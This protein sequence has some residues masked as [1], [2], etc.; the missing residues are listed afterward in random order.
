M[1]NNAGTVVAWH[2]VPGRQ[3]WQVVVRSPGIHLAG[4][5]TPCTMKGNM[6]CRQAQA[7][8]TT[9]QVSHLHL[10]HHPSSSGRWHGRHGSSQCMVAANNGIIK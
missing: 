4:K 6:N 1:A 2:V 5:I 10:P 8:P 9:Q 3:V 7:S